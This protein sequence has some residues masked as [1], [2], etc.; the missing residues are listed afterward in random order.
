MSWLKV[1]DQLL[2]N[3]ESASDEV[4]NNALS[5]I[6]TLTEI[7]TDS[8]EVK[9]I[10][11]RLRNRGEHFITFLRHPE[12]PT[13][14]NPAELKLKHVIVHR[15]DGKPFRSLGAMEEYGT[16]L[17]VFTTWTMQGFNL[18]EKLDTIIKKSISQSKLLSK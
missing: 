5:R 16:M 12:L 4:Y 3:N 7:E 6:Y 2:E 9:K 13:T 1:R 14:N 11:K 10:Q 8:K 17:T 15:S 18:R